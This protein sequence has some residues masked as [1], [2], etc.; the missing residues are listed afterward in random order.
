[1]WRL[2]PTTVKLSFPEI[3]Y[4]IFVAFNPNPVCSKY[5]RCSPYFGLAF[6]VIFVLKTSLYVFLLL[7]NRIFLLLSICL[8]GEI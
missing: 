7:H 4:V 2:F 6:L 1:M 3:L 8:A 5:Y